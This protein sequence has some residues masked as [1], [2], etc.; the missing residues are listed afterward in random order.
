MAENEVQ[1]EAPAKETPKKKYVH[2]LLLS[3]VGGQQFQLNEVTESTE[4]P[5]NVAAFINAWRQN[6]DVWHSPGNDPHFGVRVKDVSMYQLRTLELT[7]KKPEEVKPFE[8]VAKESE[9]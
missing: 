6:K 2:V 3:L 1:T 5:A 9:A 7:E 8:E 4:I